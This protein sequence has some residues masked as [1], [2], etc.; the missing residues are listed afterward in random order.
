MKACHC[1]R[2]TKT[3]LCAEASPWGAAHSQPGR[4]RRL[5]CVAPGDEAKCNGVACVR[6]RAHATERCNSPPPPPRL[7]SPGAPLLVLG[8]GTTVL[9]LASPSRIHTHCT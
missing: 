7:A 6:V 3:Q 8:T 5:H 9:T 1:V 4:E 2:V